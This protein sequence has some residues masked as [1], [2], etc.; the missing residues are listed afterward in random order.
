MPRGFVSPRELSAK[1]SGYFLPQERRGDVQVLIQLA[2][3]TSSC[4]LANKVL[5]L[6]KEVPK[7]LL[8]SNA[9]QA[10]QETA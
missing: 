1:S 10:K 6:G 2:K 8:C 3:H 9:E 5:V 7:Y 4:V